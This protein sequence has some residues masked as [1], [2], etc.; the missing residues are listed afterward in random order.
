MN[1]ENYIIGNFV[2]D[3]VNG[4]LTLGYGNSDCDNADITEL[5]RVTIP[6]D[7]ELCSSQIIYNNQPNVTRVDGSLILQLT[8]I[9]YQ[10][11]NLPYQK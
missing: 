6:T 3:V 9:C 4:D 1:Q 11:K 7:Y 2:A 10:M 5:Q 8:M